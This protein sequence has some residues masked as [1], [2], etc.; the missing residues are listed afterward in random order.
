MEMYATIV[1][2]ITDEVLRI[3]RVMQKTG[4]GHLLKRERLAVKDKLLKL[5]SAV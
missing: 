4:Y 3:L 5:H 1:Y 2:V